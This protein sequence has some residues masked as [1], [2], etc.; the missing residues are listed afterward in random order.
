M[1]YLFLLGRL[2]YGGYFLRSGYNHLAHLSML[3][4]YAE[5]KGV[6][7]AKPAVAFS[8]LLLMLGGLGI[9]TGLYIQLAVLCLA[10]FL[11]PVTFMM[12]N[13]WKVSDPNMKMSEQIHFMKNMALL[14]AALML[15]AIPSPWMLSL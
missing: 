11:I 5:S 3:S 12:H 8:G 9:I 13:F 1:E 15:L 4:G 10:L 2:I 14:G 7:P 6:K